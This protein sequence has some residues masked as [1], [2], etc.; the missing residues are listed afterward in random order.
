MCGERH[1]GLLRSFTTDRQV[2][3]HSL[4]GR[5]GSSQSSLLPLGLHAFQAF[6]W[7]TLHTPIVMAVYQCSAMSAKHGLLRTTSSS[8]VV[9]L[10]PLSWDGWQ[11]DSYKLMIL[12]GTLAACAQSCW[13]AE[14][15]KTL[16]FLQDSQPP[17]VGEKGMSTQMS[18]SGIT[19]A[20]KYLPATPPQR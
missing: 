7:S 4:P 8:V 19:L 12:C 14:A 13:L 11:T 1:S 6:L 10:H 5:A 18:Q 3:T 15:C 16:L 20:Y 17:V 2:A 9:M